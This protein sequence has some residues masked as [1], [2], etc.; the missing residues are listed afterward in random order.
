MSKNNSPDQPNVAPLNS[1]K[2]ANNLE[3]TVD[4]ALGTVNTQASE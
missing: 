4:E 1:A 3:A 2:G